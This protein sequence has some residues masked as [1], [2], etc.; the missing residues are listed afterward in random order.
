MATTAAAAATTTIGV[1][2][3]VRTPS[4]DISTRRV[5]LYRFD[6]P[7]SSS[8]LLKVCGAA[9][10]RFVPSA[11]ASPN[12]VL[13]EEAFKGFR[14]LSKSPLEEGEDEEEEYGSD[15][16]NSEEEESG[17]SSAAAGQD[18]DELAIASLDLPPQLVSTL[19]KRGITHLFPIQVRPKLTRLAFF[20]QLLIRCLLDGWF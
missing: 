7:R 12:S 1:S 6:K 14:R 2:S 10:R 5:L 15:A 3:L 4:L 20:L 8:S 9:P 11:I 19:E 17:S 16:S 18:K 13:S